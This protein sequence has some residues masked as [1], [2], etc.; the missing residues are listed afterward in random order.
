[1]MKKETWEKGRI[2]LSSSRPLETCDI[3][4]GIARRRLG[5]STDQ[6]DA[7]IADANWQARIMP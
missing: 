6:D 4:V 1:M 7:G 5:A 3:Y 2:K